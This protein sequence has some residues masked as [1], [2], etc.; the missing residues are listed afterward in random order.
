MNMNISTLTGDW[1]LR[2]TF[3]DDFEGFKTSM[4]ETSAKVV[5]MNIARELEL[6]VEP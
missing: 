6:K 2:P 5:N 4:E 1:R 3:T